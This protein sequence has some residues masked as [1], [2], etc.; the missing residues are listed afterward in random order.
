MFIL[1]YLFLGFT[2]IFERLPFW[3][4]HLKS[5]GYF[6]IIY[7][8]SLY[9]KKIV[10][11]NLKNA[12]PEK[13]AIE[14]KSLSKNYYRHLCDLFFEIIK[15]NK[16]SSE[17]LQNRIKFKDD[18]LIRKLLEDHTNIIFCGG[19]QGN[20]EWAG[21]YLGLKF[22]K[23]CYAVVKP[24]SNVFY[25]RYI[26][27]VRTRFGMKLIPFKKTSRFLYSVQKDQAFLM[28]VAD[29]SPAKIDPKHWVKF[30]NQITPFYPGIDKLARKLEAPLVFLEIQKTARSYYEIVPTLIAEQPFKMKPNE[31]LEKYVSLLEESINNNPAYWLWSHRRWKHKKTLK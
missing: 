10:S 17:E 28:I 31:I 18:H 30:L 26:S 2:K 24:L 8:F 9:R 19:H 27:R 22:N 1:N 13:S 6:F 3:F 25:E 5:D 21:T 4:L 11:Q 16:M 15:L 7:Y 14:L 20:W 23:Q 12:F 29:Q